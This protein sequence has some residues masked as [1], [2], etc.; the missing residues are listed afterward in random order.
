MTTKNLTPV[1][2]VKARP[3]SRPCPRC[4]GVGELEMD[5]STGIHPTCPDCIGSEVCPKCGAAMQMVFDVDE[6]PVHLAC[7][8]T[9]CG[10]VWEF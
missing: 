1:T 6:Y 8:N 2:P 4:D 7:Q 9:R 5:R 3:T 10:F